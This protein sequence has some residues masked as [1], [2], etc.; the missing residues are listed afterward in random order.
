MK[1]REGFALWLLRLI[2]VSMLAIGL[3]GM[4]AIAQKEVT[5]AYGAEPGNM[6]PHASGGEASARANMFDSLV[7]R[8]PNTLELVDGLTDSWESSND[9]LRWTFH[10]R[11]GVTFH[12]GEPFT[13]ED[14]KWTYENRVMGENSVVR[15]QFE[16]VTEL[17]V[18]D[19]H[20]VEFVTSIPFPL[21]P[22][23]LAS[24]FFIM[25]SEYFQEVGEEGFNEQPIGTGPFKFV[26]WDQNERIVME[27]NPGYYL[28]RP[29]VDRAVWRVIPETSTRLAELMSGGVDI[30]MQVPPE[31][32]S[33]LE[34]N[35]N[36]RVELR[37]SVR[38]V[39][40]GLR[41]DREPL[42]DPRVR[43]ALNL[44]INKD[45]LVNAVLEGQAYETP[46][47]LAPVVFGYTPGIEGY[48]YD[49]DE[50][51]SLLAEAGYPDGFTI[52]ME[53]PVGRYLK[54][55]EVAEWVAGELAEIG[56]DVD[57]QIFEWGQYL[58]KY[59][60]HTFGD[61]YMLGWGGTAYD[62]DFVF[63]NLFHSD[64]FRSYYSNPEVDRLTEEARATV[65][66]EERLA[67]YEDLSE[68]VVEDAPWIFLFGQKDAWGLSERVNWSPG[69]TEY[70]WLHGVDVE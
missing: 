13:A 35:P 40:F 4:L 7:R 48:G 8:D 37:D 15:T 26:E 61:I 22:N 55:K 50:A 52:S 16:P 10:L 43:Q 69:Q 57:L 31:H 70:L 62:A 42:D 63:S 20:T 19:D 3:A 21:L 64:N 6:L 25:P 30:V 45:E 11:E 58:E 12:N 41:T 33:I 18:I 66:P 68:L 5:I 17:N 49:P 27:A 9:G 56:V 39:F 47:P 38:V 32:V 2:A 29:Q 60:G 53:A 34:S 65:D 1:V 28:G 54:D 14:V 24:S 36:T 51:R 59:R 44:A 67:Y 46:G 23:Y